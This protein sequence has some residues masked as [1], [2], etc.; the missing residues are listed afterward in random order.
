MSSRGHG[1][2]ALENR[3]AILEVCERL[4][5][6][7]N[8]ADEALRVYNNAGIEIRGYSSRV[9][10]LACVFE[11]H[12]RVGCPRTLGEVCALDGGEVVDD[13]AKV[14]HLMGGTSA[15]TKPSD[16]AKRFGVAGQ[17][18]RQN[19]C[20]QTNLALSLVMSGQT[21]KE[22]A[23]RCGVSEQ[24]LKVTQRP[25][26]RV[27]TDNTVVGHGFLCPETFMIRGTGILGGSK[28]MYLL[29]NYPQ[30]INWPGQVEVIPYGRRFA[31]LSPPLSE[32]EVVTRVDLKAQFG[33]GTVLT[34]IFNTGTIT[35]MGEWTGGGDICH[36]TQT[37]LNLTGTAQVVHYLGG[38]LNAY[39]WEISNLA[40]HFNSESTMVLTKVAEIM[41]ESTHNSSS[42]GYNSAVIGPGFRITANTIQLHGTNPVEVCEFAIRM[43]ERLERAGIPIASSPSRS[44]KVTITH[45]NKAPAGY[46]LMPNKRG[47]MK[48]Y[49]LP[50]ESHRKKKTT[51]AR[52][53]A[54]FKRC[55]ISIPTTIIEQF[56]LKAHG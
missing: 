14:H 13:V 7:G 23:E 49:K 47:H 46:Y 24:C 28:L 48:P 15:N 31:R 25:A 30:D 4:S 1:P 18:V 12:L 27:Q 22:A 3:L 34:K 39:E 9:V 36:D 19:A 8:T 5:C 52:V 38:D 37:A 51:Q 41:E 21:T 11:A 6:S 45:D 43:K 35:C 10:Q 40:A 55:G 16:V 20:L 26:E 44:S 2:R 33:T 53:V 56:F 42:K 50:S 54:A 29:C 17:Q 32:D